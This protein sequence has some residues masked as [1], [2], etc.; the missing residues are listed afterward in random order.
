M[1]IPPAS[2]AGWKV[3]TVGDDIAWL[4]PGKDGR[5][6]AINPESGY[7][8]VVPGTNAKTNRNAYEMIR[9]D[10]IFTNVAVTAGQ[11]ALVGRSARRQTGARLAGAA[12]RPG[13]RRR[14]TSEFPLHGGGRTKSRLLEARGRAGRRA[15]LGH[16]VRRPAPLAGAAGLSGAQLA[17]RSPGGRGT[18]LGDDRRGHRGGRR[19]AP[20]SDG[21]E[22]VRR[23]QLRGLLGALDQ[24]RRQAQIA[25]ADLSRQL[26]PAGRR[27]QVSVAGVRRESAGAALDHRA[28]QGQRRRHT[29][30]SSDS[31]RTPPTWTPA[32]WS[33]RRGARGAARGLAGRVARR[34]RG[35]RRLSR[36][37]SANGCRRH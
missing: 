37:S 2:Y 5:L 10:T 36:R 17:A 13:Q 18:R 30:R 35:R 22:A 11:R 32:G 12:V 27:R 15:D 26:V 33:S 14:R 29:T 34:V 24:R 23:L 9:R 6:Y 20:R 7:F 21:D 8:G 16:R 3:W 1:L 28:L 25:A 31:C 4:H 19:R